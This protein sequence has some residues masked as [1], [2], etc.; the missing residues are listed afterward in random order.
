MESNTC[1][2]LCGCEAYIGLSKVECSNKECKYYKPEEIK[3]EPISPK[4]EEDGLDGW[5]YGEPEP[6][7]NKIESGPPPE[8]S[9]ED[10]NGYLILD[11]NPN[12]RYSFRYITTTASSNSDIPIIVS[13]SSSISII[14]F[15]G[16][17]SNKTFTTINLTN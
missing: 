4:S 12:I 8:N 13:S 2:P 10:P 6:E 11:S 9:S 17:D 16:T 3:S 1:C 15:S 7:S 5:N 14:K